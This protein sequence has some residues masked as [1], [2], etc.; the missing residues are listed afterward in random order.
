VGE[1][2]NKGDAEGAD[3][4]SVPAPQLAAPQRHAH[5]VASTLVAPEAGQVGNVGG[6]CGAG[7]HGAFDVTGRKTGGGR[8]CR[9]EPVVESDG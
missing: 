4:V 2:P 6:P 3:V 5:H 1:P 8:A 7:C 9:A